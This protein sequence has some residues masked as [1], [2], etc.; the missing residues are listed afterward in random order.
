MTDKLHI[1]IDTVENKHVILGLVFPEFP[2]IFETLYTQ[3][4]AEE[5]MG[6]APED[7]DEHRAEN[8]FFVPPL[9]Y[10]ILPG[11]TYRWRNYAHT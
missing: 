2:D 3:L 6:T 9:S 10:T 8:N 1:A 11:E 5:D 7:W 4:K